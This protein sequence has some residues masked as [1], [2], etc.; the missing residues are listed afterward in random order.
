M[1]KS[2]YSCALTPKVEKPFCEVHCNAMLA[3]S[4]SVIYCYE[5]N[6]SKPRGYDMHLS[7]HS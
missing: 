2:F 1:V 4:V 3:F 7:S 6:Y 5:S